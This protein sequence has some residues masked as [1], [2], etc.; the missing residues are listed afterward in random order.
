MAITVKRNGLTQDFDERKI[1]ASVYNASLNAHYS[2][3][4]AEGIAENVCM[5]V[6]KLMKGVSHVDSSEIRDKI[7]EVLDDVDKDVCILYK[8]HLDIN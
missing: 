3:E 4:K 1:Y 7:I 6:K 5:Q 2:D 8:H